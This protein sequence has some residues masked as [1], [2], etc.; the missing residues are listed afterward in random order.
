MDPLRKR[1]T[2]TAGT[3]ILSDME[4]PLFWQ[5]C[6]LPPVTRRVGLALRLT[7]L[8]A[9]RADEVAGLRHTELE[10]LDDPERAAWI[11]PSLRSKNRLT[12]YV[13]LSALAVAT[14]KSAI[15]LTADGAGAPS[16]AC[17]AWWPDHRTRPGGRNASSK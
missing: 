9:A 3:R 6:V 4:I 1:G 17:G 8:T 2:E 16:I 13:P 11:L 15:E 10:Y 14:I 5:R 7:L 12:Y